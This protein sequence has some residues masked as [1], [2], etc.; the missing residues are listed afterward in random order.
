MIRNID[1][2]D[3]Q[4]S[5]VSDSVKSLIRTAPVPVMTA[6]TASTPTFRNIT[7]E[8]M[9]QYIAPKET[10]ILPSVHTLPAGD[11][12]VSRPIGTKLPEKTAGG[13]TVQQAGMGTVAIVVL[14]LI[15]AGSIY[16]H[17]KQTK[18]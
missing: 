1:S 2:Y 3:L 4:T 12:P 15:A 17:F 18:S 8:Q 9:A 11:Q 13:D 10:D 16:K 6:A 5:N 7:P 14:A